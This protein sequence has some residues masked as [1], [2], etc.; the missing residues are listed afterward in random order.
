LIIT[1]SPL[2]LGF[3][4]RYPEMTRGNGTLVCKEPA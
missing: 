1:A 3:G 2:A 4:C